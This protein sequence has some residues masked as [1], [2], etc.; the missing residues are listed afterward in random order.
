MKNKR[1][2]SDIYSYC[3][4]S[5]FERA[6]KLLEDNYKNIDTMY[7]DGAF[8]DFAI[9]KNNVEM[10]SSLLNNYY[11]KNNLKGDPQSYDL[12]QKL[13]KHN[14]QQVL[15]NA[16]NTF[17]VSPKIEDVL[18]KY[19]ISIQES[20]DFDITEQEDHFASTNIS[21]TDISNLEA[22]NTF[23]ALPDNDYI[24]KLTGDASNQEL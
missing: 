21:Y 8:F 15:S 6:R 3:S 22:A 7:E 19:N 12:E 4:L 24:C 10:L 18:K 9:S 23:H 5:Q 16:I 17:S 14:I 13:A 20:D 2:H 1:I 11:Y